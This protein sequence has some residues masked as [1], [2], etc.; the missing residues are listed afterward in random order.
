MLCD[1][2]VHANN[3]CRASPINQQVD[4]KVGRDSQSQ[5]HAFDGSLQERVGKIGISFLIFDI[6][7]RE[8]VIVTGGD[9][10]EFDRPCGGASCS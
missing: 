9:V 1:L 7:P 8:S 3:Y 4:R 2:L 5:L 6:L 10:V